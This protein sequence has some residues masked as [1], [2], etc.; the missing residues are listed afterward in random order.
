MTTNQPN[1]AAFLISVIIAFLRQSGGE[2][3]IKLLLRLPLL[4][5]SP[6]SGH[7]RENGILL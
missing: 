7:R 3:R 4:N 6:T 2:F 1:S 5:E